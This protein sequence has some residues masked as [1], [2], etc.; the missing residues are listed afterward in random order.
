MAVRGDAEDLVRQAQAGLA[1]EPGNA[2]Q[3]AAAVGEFTR[4]S[5]AQREAMGQAGQ[6]FYFDRLSMA[7]GVDKFCGLF[8][9]LA[10]EG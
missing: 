5:P 1:C 3:L 6:R 4:L 9:G 8:A 10:G 2:A 7:R